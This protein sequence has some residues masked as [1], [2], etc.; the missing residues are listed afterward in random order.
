VFVSPKT[1]V[2]RLCDRLP[3]FI[4]YTALCK[5]V[6]YKIFVESRAP[7]GSQQKLWFDLS[8]K[9]CR[10]IPY[11]DEFHSSFNHTQQVA[12]IKLAT[13]KAVPPT[14]QTEKLLG[15]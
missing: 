8:A 9:R 4:P 2:T 12:M 14:Q 15:L 1:G 7:H 6:W 3:D 11:R 5:R 10:D 13:S